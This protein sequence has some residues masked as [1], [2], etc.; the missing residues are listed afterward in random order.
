MQTDRFKYLRMD[1][2]ARYNFALGLRRAIAV[3]QSGK[4]TPEE[5]EQWVQDVLKWAL[6]QE[7]LCDSPPTPDPTAELPWE[8]RVE[9]N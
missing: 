8:F 2:E 5:L 9:A 6:D 7:Q 1:R 3:F 4:H